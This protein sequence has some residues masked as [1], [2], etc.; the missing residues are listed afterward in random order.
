[1][2][3]V[4]ILLLMEKKKQLSPKASAVEDQTSGPE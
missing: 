2:M 1:M 4:E 3:Q